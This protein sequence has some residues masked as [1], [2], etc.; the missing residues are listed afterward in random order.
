[1]KSVRIAPP[2]GHY[3]KVHVPI[4]K[5]QQVSHVMFGFIEWVLKTVEM[6]P[7]AAAYLSCSSGSKGWYVTW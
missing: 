7:W 6:N 2:A 4:N 1:M 5:A 3:L